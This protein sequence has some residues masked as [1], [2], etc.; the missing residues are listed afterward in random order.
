LNFT[1]I[2]RGTKGKLVDFKKFTRPIQDWLKTYNVDTVFEGKNN[3]TIHGKKISG[4]AEHVFKN[5]ILHHGTLLYSSEMKN[6]SEALKVS[7]DAYED[8]AVKSIHSVVTNIAPHMNTNMDIKSFQESLMSYIRSVNK[9]T[10]EYQFTE[11]DLLEIQ[12]LVSNKY[13]TWEWIYGYSPSYIFSKSAE[14]GSKRISIWLKVEK[15]IIVEA[16]IEGDYFE[17]EILNQLREMVVGQAHSKMAFSSFLEE[18]PSLSKVPIPN[19]QE[20]TSIFY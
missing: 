16:R 18:L 9:E 5:R 4:N 1:F 12:E 3:L 13:N 10:R 20:L 14:L 11:D 6:L 8:K 2:L 15:G 17:N 7:L 19:V